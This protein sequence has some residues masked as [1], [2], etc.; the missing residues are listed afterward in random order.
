MSIRFLAKCV[1]DLLFPEPP[2]D[3]IDE[4]EFSKCEELW[5]EV[6]GRKKFEEFVRFEDEFRDD[7]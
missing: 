5:F 3:W 7:D 6:V 1:V 4:D 2:R